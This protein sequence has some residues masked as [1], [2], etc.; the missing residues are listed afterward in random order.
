MDKVNKNYKK[1]LKNTFNAGVYFFALVGFLLTAG[2][3]GVKLG[4]TNT[5]GIIDEQRKG[6]FE[7]ENPATPLNIE[8]NKSEEWVTLREALIKD[9]AVINQ[10]SL[11]TGV[12]ARLIASVIVVEQLRLFHSDRELFK[13]V[14][15][16]LKIL[17]TQSQFSWGVSGIKPDT[18]KTI[19]N[20]LKDNSS[21]YYLGKSFEEKLNFKTEN[22]DEERFARMTD[23]KERY[24]SY[25][26]TALLM[27]QV[28][29]QWARAGFPIEK[30][31]GVVTTLF[32]IGFERSNPKPNPNIG[33]AEIKIEGK[34]YSFGGLAEEFYYSNELLDVFPKR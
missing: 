28:Q 31:I 18:A 22:I 17:G 33:G 14:F 12:E 1:I 9:S 21:P 11:E 2:Y 8:W 25:L 3:F 6:F 16:P 30:N 26:Y 19:E 24:F 27:K 23:Y 32:N 13:K 5:R 7:V 20:N 4:L 34:N 29:T 10:V 15:A